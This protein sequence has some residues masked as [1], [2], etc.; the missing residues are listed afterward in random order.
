[1][2]TKCFI[3]LLGKRLCFPLRQ[4]DYASVTYTRSFD[5]AELIARSTVYLK[6]HANLMK[7][8]NK[9]NALALWNVKLAMLQYTSST[10]SHLPTVRK[11]L[12][13]IDL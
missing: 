7:R 13:G 5:V 11:I 2:I 8:I 3:K 4:V 1:M 6:C 9:K 10:I 12:K